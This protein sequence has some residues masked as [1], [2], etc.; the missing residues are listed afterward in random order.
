MNQWG[1]Q[2]RLLQITLLPSLLIALVLGAYFSYEHYQHQHSQYIKQSI[3][4]SQQLAIHSMPLFIS[5]QTSPENLAGYL[6]IPGLRALAL[7]TPDQRS[8]AKIGPNMLPATGTIL[9][10][11]GLH[12]QHGEQSLRI[13]APVFSPN[14]Q[15]SELLGWVELEFQLADLQVIQYQ[16]LIS[17]LVLILALCILAVYLSYR[18]SVRIISPLQQLAH[19]LDQLAN[20]NLESRVKLTEQT[21]FSELARGINSMA[22][23]LQN[24]HQEL[25]D[26]VEQATQDLKQTMD[27]LEVQNIE[28]NLAR[29]EAVGANKTKSEF[30]ANMSHEIRTPLNGILGFSDLLTKTELTTQQ[31]EY[32]T[33]ITSSSAGLLNIINDILD[34]SKIE[35][36]K[37]VLD[38]APVHLRDITDEVLTMLAPEAH[39]KG[40][41]LAALVYQDVPYEIMADPTR[42]K[43]VIT[44]LVNNAI[45]FT[46]HGSVII[47]IM[48]EESL[49]EKVALKFTIT[50]TGIGLSH[51][52]QKK[53]F[54]AFSQGDTSTTRRYGG[55]GLGLVIS[56]YLVKH[57]QGEIGLT[58]EPDVGSTF[59]FTGQFTTSDA[60][61]QDWSDAPWFRQPAYLMSLRG[62]TGQAL[63]HQLSNLGFEVSVYSCLKQL[64]AQ[65]AIKPAALCCVEINQDSDQ[66][67]LQSIQHAGPMIGLLTNNEQQNI[68]QLRALNLEHTLVYPIAFRRLARCIQEQ[69]GMIVNSNLI[70]P[71]MNAEPVKVLAVDD[72]PPN[73]ELI[74]TWLESLGVDVVKANGGL[75]AVELA[76]QQNFDL[77]F[78]D[79]QMPDLDGVLAAKYIHR[80]SLNSTTPMM[81]LTAH[82][83]PNERKQLMQNGFDDYLTKPINEDLLIHTLMKWTRY[84][85]KPMVKAKVSPPMKPS[86]ESVVN[87][88]VC[89]QLVGGNEQLAQT[90]LEGLILEAKQLQDILPITPKDALME[91]IHKL[92]GLSKYVGAAH[93]RSALESAEV[94]LKTQGKNWPTCQGDLSIAIANLLAWHQ[95]SPLDLVNVT[96]NDIH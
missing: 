86:T 93:L 4:S 11:N 54:K 25:Q 64:H 65:Q 8:Q 67:L 62:T 51:D 18:A 23:N 53:L 21:E 96:E 13:K 39:K 95:Q 7:L 77:I 56:H 31:Q 36:G 83:L 2:R 76:K 79:I 45:K 66:E 22:S 27:V 15:Q 59:W 6:E 10:E 47:R 74:S 91:P 90:M 81:A 20:G 48:L 34:F 52:Q 70:L 61:M 63:Q 12:I 43:Q 32:L 72:N 44:N 28:L 88:Q 5:E 71:F 35:A 46:E 58:S 94:C 87:W 29:R 42:I 14:S 37:L 50:D 49:S 75:P 38:H 33:T 82:A 3:V 40:I 85:T 60:T 30:L 73:L 68:T 80:D 19:T 89:L 84:Q 78:M 41:E 9:I 1:I 57:M 69:L 16:T 55:T 92:H 24:A 17:S 26:N